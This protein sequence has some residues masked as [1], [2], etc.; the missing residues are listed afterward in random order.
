MPVVLQAVMASRP[1]HQSLMLAMPG[2]ARQW[3]GAPEAVGAFCDAYAPLIHADPPYTPATCRIEAVYSYFSNGP[4]RTAARLALAADDSPYL[5]GLRRQE[6]MTGALPQDQAI[7]ALERIRATRPLDRDEAELWDQLHTPPGEI[8]QSVA[9]PQAVRDAVAQHRR[10]A[11]NVP[12]DPTTFDQLWGDLH[13]DERVNNAPYPADEMIARAKAILAVFPQDPMTLSH[14]GDDTVLYGGPGLSA[15][16]RIVAAEP[17][18]EASIVYS[19]HDA[20]R[21]RVA[22]KPKLNLL[23][24]DENRMHP[25]ADDQLP[26]RMRAALEDALICPALRQVK[27]LQAVCLRDGADYCLPRQLHDPSALEMLLRRG[28]AC[29]AALT[30]DVETLI[31]LPG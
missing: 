8:L 16:D 9:Y 15:L 23:L 28:S 31:Y 18:F 6:L 29:P 13:E 30:D 20:A 4:E 24:A 25:T 26:P 10:W 5:D 22:M 12:L 17:Y 7:A 11:I 14:L 19:L 27:L 21:L 3:G 2:L 1:N